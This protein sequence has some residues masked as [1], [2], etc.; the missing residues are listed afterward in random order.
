MC[1]NFI[2]KDVTSYFRYPGK[3]RKIKGERG[4]HTHRG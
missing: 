3:I 4:S 1:D 2:L